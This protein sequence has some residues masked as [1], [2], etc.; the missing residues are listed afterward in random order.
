MSYVGSAIGNIRIE[1]RLGRGGMGEVYLGYDARLERRVA[2]KTIRAER[3]LSA[4]NKA[5][6]LR[7]ARLLGKLGH[8]AICRVYDLI[9]TPEADF[10]VLEYIEGSTLAALARRGGLS[11]ERRLEL[12]EQIA[13]ALAVA[14]REQIVHRDLKADNV[15]ITREGEVKVLD[16]GVARSLSEPAEIRLAGP[17]PL[18]GLDPL[19]SDEAGE[20]EADG[21]TLAEGVVWR[22]GEREVPDAATGSVAGP[23][24]DGSGDDGS[25]ALTRQGLLVGSLQAMS[26]EQ[27]AG[28]EIGTASDLYSF[29]ILL[30]EL[31]TGE[32]AYEAATEPALLARVLRA[33]TRPLAP[34]AGLDPDLIG[35]LHDLQSLDPR[36]R[37]TAAEAAERLR[38]LRAKPQRLRQRRRRRAAAAAAFAVLAIGLAVVSWLAIEADHARRESERRRRQAE[39]LIGFMVGDLRQRLER[40]NRLDIL[41]AVGD[42]ALAYFA[43]VREGELTPAELVGRI[44]AIRQIGEV[45][46]AQGSLPAA[47]AAFRRAAEL[48]GKLA[49]R[50]PELRA[51]A[52]ELVTAESWVGQVLYDQHRAQEALAAWLGAEA[53]A[54]AQLDRRPG[55]RELASS[56]AVAEHNVGT[57]RELAGDL[58]GALRDLRA[59]LAL[60]RAVTRRDPADLESQ[61]ASAA[62]LAFVSNILERQG[63]LAGALAARR[64][65][66]ALAAAL[67]ARDPGNPVRRYDLG[68]ARGFLAGLLAA[69]G[70]RAA[71]RDEYGR[72]LALFRALAA[73]DPGNA[74]DQRWLGVFEGATGSL[75]LGDGDPRAA[76]AAFGRSRAILEPLVAKDPANPDFRLQLGVNR[77]NAAAAWEPLDPARALAEAAAADAIL[78]PLA[79]GHPGEPTRGLLAEAALALG[80]LEAARGD[81]SAARAARQ[82]AVA[83]LAPCRRP[84]DNWKLLA[85]WARANLSLERTAEARP[86]VERL[87]RMGVTLPDLEA[88]ARAQGI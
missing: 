11:A 19:D 88:L 2:V 28:G 62:T 1:S 48:G 84:L 83:L 3:R 27:A 17:P 60:Q 8:P 56:L 63:D 4:V 18:P 52:D 67:A 58:D 77:S 61:A 31:A 75:A 37:P 10:L 81:S 20:I 13:L 66:L 86:A 78:A 32:P 7:E 9:E 73:E 69:R 35:L 64:E 80:R 87:R 25:T 76:V 34:S 74:L 33:E 47:L 16:F 53:L 26:P 41:D 5:R 72:G 43:D 40:V 51:A 22:A 15:M 70:E 12:A 71:A 38:A 36:R 65:H 23:F 46:Y 14:H 30:Q 42:R 79:A 50:D 55:D 54:E 21:P 49:D 57:A 39:G 29:G 85:T 6:F 59:S 44:Q 45:R 82:R 24:T 68:V